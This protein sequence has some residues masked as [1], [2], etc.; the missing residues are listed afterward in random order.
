MH[1][2]I[3]YRRR[4]SRWWR[5]VGIWGWWNGTGLRGL[6]ELG[7]I[8]P[9]EFASALRRHG[10]IRLRPIKI[11]N[12]RTEVYAAAMSVSAVAGIG[13]I[14]RYQSTKIAVEPV[15]IAVKSMPIGGSM[16]IEAMPV[17]V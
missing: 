12:I 15:I 11:E 5:S 1:N 16:M 2:I 17:L 7:S 9:T 10:E 14:G 13:S 6:V 8:T 4:Q 3:A